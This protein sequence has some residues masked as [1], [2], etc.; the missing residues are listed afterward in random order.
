MKKIILSGNVSREPVYSENGRIFFGL[1][2]NSFSKGEKQAAEFYNVS[3]SAHFAEICKKCEIRKGSYVSLLIGE[4]VYHS[5]ATAFKDSNGKT[6]YNN[7]LTVFIEQIE[8]PPKSAGSVTTAPAEEEPL[9]GFTAI[10][11]GLTSFED[12]LF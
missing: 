10:A 4:P 9:K 5:E 7:N 11:E 12:D 8:F 6:I 1:A 3:G 2:V